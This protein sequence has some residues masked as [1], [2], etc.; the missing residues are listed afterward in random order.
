MDIEL[1]NIL[2]PIAPL[3]STKANNPWNGMIKVHLRKPQIAGLALLTGIRIFVMLLDGELKVPKI[4]KGFDNLAYND[5]L[6][7]NIS[8]ETLKGVVHHDVLTK[9]VVTSFYRG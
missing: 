5:M 1:G 4:A 6:T 3:C 8:D 7:V 2:E 9:I